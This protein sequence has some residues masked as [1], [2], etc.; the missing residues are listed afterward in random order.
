MESGE[1]M[2]EPACVVLLLAD[3]HEVKVEGTLNQVRSSIVGDKW[4]DFT[5]T[6]GQMVVV[7][8]SYVELLREYNPMQ[9]E[10]VGWTLELS[11]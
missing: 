6:Q 11:E 4:V 7:N 10:R 9:L 3:G 2:T 8:S 5:N 1:G